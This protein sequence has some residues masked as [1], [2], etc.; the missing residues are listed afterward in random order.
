MTTEPDNK[1]YLLSAIAVSLLFFLT[2]YDPKAVAVF[3]TWA[4][5]I[6]LSGTC[7]LMAIVAVARAI[8][9]FRSGE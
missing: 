4:G 9:L 7:F 2:L 1:D 3:A 8:K 6:A 5:V